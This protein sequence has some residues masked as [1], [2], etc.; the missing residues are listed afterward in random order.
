MSHNETRLEQIYNDPATGRALDLFERFAQ[1]KLKNESDLEAFLDTL[2]SAQAKPERA[3]LKQIMADS[4]VRVEPDLSTRTGQLVWAAGLGHL[5]QSSPPDTIRS[6]SVWD[7]L[8][9]HPQLSGSLG[10]AARYIDLSLANRNT[11]MDWG[12]PGSWF[13]FSPDKDHVN[14]D[15]FHTL[16]LGLGDDIAPGVKGLAHATG[17]MMHEVGHALYTTRFSDGMKALRDKESEILGIDKEELKK[18]TPAEF[19]KNLKALPPDKL[20]AFARNR[21]E[22]GLRA[23]LF[24]A[25]E[26]NCVNRYAANQGKSFPHD[27]GNSLNICNVVLQGSGLHMRTEEEKAA[28]NAQENQDSKEDPRVQEAKEQLQKINAALALAFYSTNGL[29]D[30][31]DEKTWKKLGIDPGAIVAQSGENFEHLMAQAIGSNGVA[32]L[33]P[34]TR[35][36]WLFRSAFTQS[37]GTFAEK[38]CRLIDEIWDKYAAHHARVILDAAEKNPENQLSQDSDTQESDG[39]E[40]DGP[41]SDGQSGGGGGSSEQKKP[42]DPSPSQGGGQGNGS[43]NPSGP[44]QGALPSTPEEARQAAR[45]NAEEENK[46]QNARTVRDLAKEAKRQAAMQAAGSDQEEASPQGPSPDDLSMGNSNQGGRQKGVDL[47]SLSAKNWRE[48]KKR[49]NE[50]EPVIARVAK[51]FAYIRERQKQTIRS[52]SRKE[53][54]ELPRSGGDLRQRLDMR[55]HINYALERATGQR[56]GENARKRWR[57]DQ[58][59]TEKTSVELWVLADG[60]LSMK[61]PLSGGGRRIDSAVQ[62]MAIFYEAGRRAGFETFAGVWGD[63]HIRIIAAPG[64]DDQKVGRNFQR[65]RDGINSGTV[66]SPAFEQ[67]VEISSKQVTSADG[68]PKRFAGM[69]HFLILSDGELNEEDIK[70][71]AKAIEKLFRHGPAVSVDIAVL[72]SGKGKEMSKV[73]AMVKRAVPTAAIG[74]IHVKNASDIPILLAGQI[75]KRFEGSGRDVLATSDTEKREA[76]SRA[77]KAIKNSKME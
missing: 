29:F 63:D 5:F 12:T 67:A 15:L 42:D 66:L 23:G 68:K 56:P 45:Q 72:G 28:G 64:D 70:A 37:V 26:D 59:E 17:V 31:A 11:T 8:T 16:L 52:L 71:A 77:H 39:Q 30:T 2:P 9:H 1:K 6:H 18:L 21:A 57:K 20:K 25:A 19:Q 3:K 49:I 22:F 58:V 44:A 43:G 62:S 75:K 27:F 13:W 38:R 36:A 76:F 4:A 32:N 55:A 50:L 54:E 51:D 53:R 65:V 47:A 35:D 14:I 40:S 69:T 60:S 41:G 73:V 34:S 61:E 48:F 24:N 10:S 74:I 46:P 7:A 33:Q